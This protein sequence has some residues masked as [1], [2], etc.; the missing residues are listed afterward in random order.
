MA[1][2]SGVSSVAWYSVSSGTSG[3]GAGAVRSRMKRIVSS[4]DGTAGFRAHPGTPPPRSP[5]RRLSADR[6]R[7]SSIASILARERADQRA[8]VRE[9]RDVGPRPDPHLARVAQDRDPEAERRGVGRR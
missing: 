9:H 2:H 3:T 5:G 1:R 8:G 6:G 4:S 7:A